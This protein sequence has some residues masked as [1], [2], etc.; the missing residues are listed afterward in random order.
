[1]PLRVQSQAQESRVNGHFTF[2]FFQ[3]DTLLDAILS[4]RMILHLRAWARRDIDMPDQWQEFRLED[5]PRSAYQHSSC[6][7]PSPVAFISPVV[8]V[9]P[10]RSEL[11]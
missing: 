2:L 9:L 11:Q 7:L 10:V 5:T 3:P 8:I 6:R 4:A 1:M